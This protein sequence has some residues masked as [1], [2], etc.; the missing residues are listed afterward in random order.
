MIL[1]TFILPILLSIGA[2][3][4]H[5]NPA[6]SYQSIV[7]QF[8]NSESLKDAEVSVSIITISDN[9]LLADH[10]PDRQLIPASSLKTVTTAS[11]LA[12][13]GPGYRYTTSLWIEGTVSEGVLKGDLILLGS[14][15]PSFTSKLLKE[16]PDLAT[17]LQQVQ[18]TLQNKGIR[19]IDGRI[20]VDEMA[21]NPQDAVA[22]SWE[23]RD[24]GNYYASGAWGLNI[25]DNLY[26]LHFR[27]QMRVGGKP[28]YD[29]VTP[30][31][32]GLKLDNQV[33]LAGRNTGDNAYIY[34]KPLQFNRKITGTIP[35]GSGRFTIKGSLPDPPAFAAYHLKKQLT[36]AGISVTGEAT[37]R[38]VLGANSAQSNRQKTKLKEWKSPPLAKLVALANVYSDNLYCEAFLR[39][40]GLAQQGRGTRTAGLQAINQLWQSR[41][42]SMAEAEF[43]DGSG[44]S[45]ENKVSSKFLASVLRKAYVDKKISP[46]YLAALPHAGNSTYYSKLYQGTAAQNRLYAK[47]GSMQTVRTY[48]GLFKDKTGNWHS[49]SILVNNISQ[50]EG[51]IKQ[52]IEKLMLDLCS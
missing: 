10:Q 39:S 48:S 13:L 42:L 8:V 20:I 4:A 52:Q 34:G 9:K 27:Q 40:I 3:P 51:Q 22:P 17:F 44:L 46:A 37:T 26:H 24:M 19:Q 2:L 38:R 5:L 45:I 31:V 41:G 6:P 49:F 15:D 16:G 25:H 11:A 29:G 28:I 35:A 14:G 50:R 47:S 18:I 33:T 32:P 21:F 1:N 12:L 30:E 7:D 23:E 43:V 36:Q